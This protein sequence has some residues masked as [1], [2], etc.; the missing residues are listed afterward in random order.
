MN[1]SLLSVALALALAGCNLAPEYQRPDAPIPGEWP[2]SAAATVQGK[3]LAETGWQDFFAD[4]RLKRVIT[5][6]LDNNRDLR[7]A[8]LNIE[9]A[10]AQYQ[11]SG[12]A[13]LPA[14]NATGAEVRN[15]CQLRSPRQDSR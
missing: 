9:K 7:V 12:S 11:I 1:R 8:V 10:R 5:L 3:S 4:T 14:I 2:A 13:Q 6:A 15:A